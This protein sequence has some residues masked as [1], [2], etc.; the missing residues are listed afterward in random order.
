MNKYVISNKMFTI[1]VTYNELNEL[2]A[3]ISYFLSFYLINSQ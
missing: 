1:F 2:T 3:L